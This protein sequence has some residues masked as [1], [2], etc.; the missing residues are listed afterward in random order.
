MLVGYQLDYLFDWTTLKYPQTGSTSRPRVSSITDFKCCGDP[1]FHNKSKI[2]S[3]CCFV[4][5]SQQL[6]PLDP[7][8]GPPAEISEKPTG[9]L[10][11]VFIYVVGLN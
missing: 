11:S 10:F 1:N 6:T 5:R 8:P 3:C 2:L 4:Y 7:P 9:T